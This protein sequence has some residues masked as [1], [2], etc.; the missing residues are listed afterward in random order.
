MP[1]AIELASSWHRVL[2]FQE[3]ADELTRDID[4]L[5]TSS[6]GIP[7]RQ[8]SIRAVLD[9]T[10]DRMTEAEKSAFMKLSIFR[11]GFTRDAATFVAATNFRLLMN[12][13][14]KSLLRRDA[15]S[16]R[17][18]IHELLRQYAAR[19]AERHSEMIQNAQILHSKYFLQLAEKLET[20]LFGI[21]QIRAFSQL[22]HEHEN[23]RV[24][25][26]W[27]SR[28]K[29]HQDIL[30][31]C[32][33][34]WF[35]WYMRG[36][37]A[38]GYQWLVKALSQVSESTYHRAKGLYSASY[39]AW[40]LDDLDEAKTLIDESLNT[41]QELVDKIG[42]SSAL[43]FK[44]WFLWWGG[45]NH[46]A[47]Q[48][49]DDSTT[50]CRNMHNDWHLAV[51]LYWLAHT[52]FGEENLDKPRSLLDECTTVSKQVGERLIRSMSAEGLGHI[53]LRERNFDTARTLY[54]EALKFRQEVGDKW[55]TAWAFHNLANV[56]EQEGNLVELKA[57]VSNQLAH[58]RDFG[59]DW[60]IATTLKRLG[61]VESLLGNG[62]QAKS[63]YGESLRISHDLDDNHRIVVLLE[64]FA[65]LAKT[66]GLF[67]RA[68]YLFSVCKHFADTNSIDLQSSDHFTADIAKLRSD[69][70][71][72]VYSSAWERGKLV[73]LDIVV[74][75]L[76]AEFEK[77]THS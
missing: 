51:G 17:F 22:K 71:N 56:A 73:D 27:L 7:E 24:A 46:T 50:L 11:G 29:Q 31:I 53:A 64:S 68:V 74:Q 38:E 28:M 18:H 26:T 61:D 6:R 63:A 3:I 75:E 44:G 47:R 34:I 58:F 54:R 36:Y 32:G 69:M 60:M 57:L 20:E 59:I 16:G 40:M 62:E 35:F 23:Y 70:A 30:Q 5:Q 41:Y 43:T 49:L 45:D 15:D 77:K 65:H 10:W 66:Q 19:K 52:Y 42:I 33:H 21:H 76:I 39:L 37:V 72:V 14:N 2:S 55:L 13:V 8:R 12:L 9:Y 48:V 67:D 1:L 4:I 25:I